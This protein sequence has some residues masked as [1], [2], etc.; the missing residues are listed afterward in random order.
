MSITVTLVIIVITAIVS[1]LALSNRDL[2]LKF[3]HYPYEEHRDKEFYRWVTSVFLHGSWMHLAINMF[4]LWSFGTFIESVFV[5]L[6]GATMGRINFAA[7]Y[8][9]SGVFADIPTYIKHKNNQSF[10]SVGASG[11]TSGIMFA[12][13]LLLPWEKIYLFGVLPIPAIVAAVLYLVYSSYSSRQEAG[14]RI[15][16]EA[17]FWGA[18][19]GFAFTVALKPS[20]FTSFLSQVVG[21]AAILIAAKF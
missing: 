18:V 15:D 9:L 2:F 13:A 16:H 1:W 8:L 12:F 6:F 10:S 4:V 17:H 5:E 20:L 3:M 19:F 11:A 14:S 21:G 7:L